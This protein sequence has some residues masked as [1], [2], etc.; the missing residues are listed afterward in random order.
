MQ[1]SFARHLFWH[2]TSAMAGREWISV[3]SQRPGWNC[4]QQAVKR[5][6][7]VGPATEEAQSM[8]EQGIWKKFLCNEL[9]K[10]IQNPP[11]KYTSS[12]GSTGDPAPQF[13]GDNQPP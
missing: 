11:L 2:S 1:E 6:G 9:F 12:I 13:P 3:E 8:E 5:L 7:R 4:E 10:E